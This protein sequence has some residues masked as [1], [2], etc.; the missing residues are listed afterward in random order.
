[1][2]MSHMVADV[3][4]SSMQKRL[5][6]YVEESSLKPVSKATKPQYFPVAVLHPTVLF[7][8]LFCHTPSRHGSL[9]ISMPW[10]GLDQD[11]SSPNYGEATECL[12][13]RHSTRV[14]FLSTSSRTCQPFVVR[15]LGITC[16]VPVTHDTRREEGA[17]CVQYVLWRVSFHK[18]PGACNGTLPQVGRNLHHAEQRRFVAG[19]IVAKKVNSDVAAQEV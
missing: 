9:H 17:P 12:L 15:R 16:V 10:H 7:L 13:S 11:W 18:G 8:K 14:L 19:K 3:V 5:E 4:V 1:M 2:K 6:L